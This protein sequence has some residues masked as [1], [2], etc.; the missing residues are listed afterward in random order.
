MGCAANDNAIGGRHIL[1]PRGDMHRHAKDFPPVVI[2]APSLS[3]YDDDPGVHRDLHIKAQR[4]G[5]LRLKP[6]LA[7]PNR[8]RQGRVNRALAIVFM[9]DG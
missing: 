4:A 8:N 3:P 2:D 1:Q 9:S 5:F 6:P 7:Y